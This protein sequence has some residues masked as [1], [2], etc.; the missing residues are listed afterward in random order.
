MNVIALDYVPSSQRGGKEMSMFQVCRGLS[1]RGHRVLF[2]HLC[3]GDLLTD[4]R[5]FAAGVLPI[6]TGRIDMKCLLG[7]SWR[8]WWDIRRVAQVIRGCLGEPASDNSV[9]YMDQDRGAGFGAL[10]S[11]LLRVPLVFHCRQPFFEA[12]PRQEKLALQRAEKLIAVSHQTRADWLRYG[13][14]PAKFTVVHNGIDTNTFTPADPAAAKKRF[15]C[16]PK[17]RVVAY[18]GRLDPEKGIDCLVKALALVKRPQPVHLLLAG[19]P[20]CHS[21]P[22]AGQRYLLGLKRL[23]Q[24]LRVANRVH[25]LGHLDRPQWLYQA[26]DLT[27]LPSLNSEPF[28]KAVV[29]SMACGVPAIASRVGGIPEILQG[30]FA[31]GLFPAGDPAALASRIQLMVD[32][33]QQT[34]SL[35][36][37]YRRYVLQHFSLETAL[38]RLEAV[39]QAAIQGDGR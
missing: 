29:E 38:R 6:T 19:G 25:F 11:L 28:G 15:H 10:L 31:V 35:G 18:V 9:I 27:V 3:E 17:N 1:Q 4:Y 37:H 2:L 8:L 36:D 21:S 22:A 24:K 23:A 33:R 34:P 7:S 12:F 5:E 32:W 26:C 16:Q 20:V 13:F 30:E 39:L 14:S